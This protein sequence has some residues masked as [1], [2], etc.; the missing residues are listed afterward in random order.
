MKQKITA[1]WWGMMTGCAL[2]AT[3]ISILQK[4]A[5]VTIFF[6]GLALILMVITA[7]YCTDH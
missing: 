1:A 7:L 6:A 3:V 4:P 2:S 5:W